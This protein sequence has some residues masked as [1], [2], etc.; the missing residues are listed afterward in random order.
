MRTNV[1]TD[2]DREK[3]LELAK[4]M[5]AAGENLKDLAQEMAVKSEKGKA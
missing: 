4:K 5:A 1:F 2:K 3:L